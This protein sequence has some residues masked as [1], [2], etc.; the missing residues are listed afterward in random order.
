MI[1]QQLKFIVWEADNQCIHLSNCPRWHPCWYRRKATAICPSSFVYKESIPICSKRAIVYRRPAANAPIGC[2]IHLLAAGSGRPHTGTSTESPGTSGHLLRRLWFHHPSWG[3]HA[4][5]GRTPHYRRGLPPSWGPYR[6]S[7]TGGRAET[8]YSADVLFHH[9][10]HLILVR[11]VHRLFEQHL[12]EIGTTRL[13]AFLSSR[14][15][16]KTLLLICYPPA[17][18]E[19]TPAV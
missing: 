14:F 7:G 19:P 13:G 15:F 16:L 18:Y 1:D 10:G 4:P 12:N 8:L 9:S 3:Y 17:F 6:G 11:H 2:P 5:E